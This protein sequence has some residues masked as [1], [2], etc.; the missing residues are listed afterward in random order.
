MDTSPRDRTI[1]SAA[2]TLLGRGAR[3]GLSTVDIVV[4]VRRDDPEMIKRIRALHDVVHDCVPLSWTITIVDVDGE[5][6]TWPWVA[7]LT[8]Q[9]QGVHAVR[10]WHGGRGAVLKAAWRHTRADIV[11]LLELDVPGAL[12]ALLP[13]VAPLVSGRADVAV[14]SVPGA[15]RGLVARTFSALL[16]LGFSAGDTRCGLFAARTEAL[17]PMLNKIQDDAPYLSTELLVLARHNRLRVHEVPVDPAPTDGPPRR[18]RPEWAHLRTLIR[19]VHA[20]VSGRAEIGGLAGKAVD[21]P[22]LRAAA[23]MK[24]AMFGV[25]GGLSGVLYVLVYL[26]LRDLSSPAVANFCALAIAAL[27]NIEVNRVWTFG[28]AKVARIGMH[29]R[30]AMLFVAH[31]TLTTGAVF[32]LL[33]FNPDAGKTV[34][35]ITLLSADMLMTI[36]RFIGLDKWIF[37][38]R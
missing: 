14:G 3:P 29:V 28:K 22:P 4:P 21:V 15:G 13:M 8:E 24:F 35:V 9:L 7:H 20:V 37:R 32:T 26:P 25:V 31:Y 10:S 17:R 2:R 19:L 5:D 11:V 6:D 18:Q 12:D 36:A 27:F 1:L 30:S 33:A 34:E 38:R 16:R 23:L